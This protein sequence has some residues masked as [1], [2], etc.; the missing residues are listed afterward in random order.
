M[1]TVAL[2]G[3]PNVGKSALFNRLAGRRIS[4][5]HDQ[6][7]VTRDRITATCDKGPF[8]FDLIDTGGIGGG[9]DESFSQ[10]V[11]TEVAIARETADI[12]LFVMDG[13][14]GLH[15]VDEELA[16]KL[17]L[18]ST[19]VIPVVNKLDHLE[20][21]NHEA[22]FSRLGFDE[23]PAAVSAAHGIGMERLLD[24]IIDKFT[25]LGVDADALAT[26]REHPDGMAAMRIA[27]VGKPNAGKSSLINAIM[28][29]NRTIVSDV[30][31][32][33]RDAVDIPYSRSDR[34]YV[35]IDTAGIR[36]KN[37]RDSTVEVF[38]AM[39]TEKSI[40][41][42]H[43][44]ILVIDAHRGISAQDRKIARII[45]AAG[46]P[47]VVVMN[48]FD[49]YHPEDK[50]RERLEMLTKDT[51]EDLFF[52]HYAPQI[53]VSAKDR[54]FLNQVFKGIE[55]VRKAAV[56]APTTAFLNTML[57]DAMRA[58]PPPARKSGHHLKLYYATLAKK[59]VPTPMP[60]PRFVLFV[61]KR[62]YL[63]QNYKK[64][65]ENEIRKVSPFTGL[66][67]IFDVR[68]KKKKDAKQGK[69]PLPPELL[70]GD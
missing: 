44:C 66:P 22:E 41:R 12:I 37:Q 14:E 58:Y 46:K 7:G 2:V 55:K 13:R 38:S 30:A 10:E 42:A 57:E 47:C 48:K 70:A 36:T 32:T 11:E 27:I 6:P 68:E 20:L 52:L 60:V 29:D 63:S 8:P 67:I 64:Y 50:F 65:L 39:R 43:I 69:T 56:N 33:T 35:L 40:H 49:L 25:E 61:N 17:R 24:R 15:P 59:E 53:A 34:D 1:P 16:R 51:G 9:A 31:G 21:E 5:V 23:A 19:S 18:S 45:L 28:K 26:A 54:E 3:R 4:I 62:L